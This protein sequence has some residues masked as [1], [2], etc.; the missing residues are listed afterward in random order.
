MPFVDET[1]FKNQS[2]IHQYPPET[3]TLIQRIRHSPPARNVKGGRGNVRA[4]FPSHKMGVTIQSES[5][6]VDQLHTV[7]DSWLIHGN[8]YRAVYE[9]AMKECGYS[10]Y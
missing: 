7:L 1:E 9:Q 10:A 2:H 6:T 8:E 4:R 3:I 5:R